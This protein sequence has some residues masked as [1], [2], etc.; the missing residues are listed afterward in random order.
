MKKNLGKL[1]AGL[2]V[3][4]VLAVIF[5]RGDQ[6]EHLVRTIEEGAP[7]FLILAVAFQMTKYLCQALSFSQCFRA[8]DARM[9][10]GECVRLVF[11]TYFLDTVIPSM[12]ISGTA[13]VVQQAT[14]RGI[15]PGRAVGAALLRQVT[16]SAAFIVIMVIGFAILA[17][18]GDLQPGWLIMGACAIVVV[19]ALVGAMV[20]AAL[21]PDWLLKVAAPFL[22]LADKVLARFKKKPVDD[23]VTQ[24]V[25]TYSTAAKLMVSNKADIAREFG[26]SVLANALEVT[27]FAFVGLAFGMHDFRVVICVYVV[28]TLSGMVSIVP[29]G[30]GVVEGA[31]LV[32]FTLFGV[33]QATGMAI[34]MVYRAIIFWLPFLIGAVL[35]QN[36][37]FKQQ[38]ANLADLMGKPAGGTGPD[39]DAAAPGRAAAKDPAGPKAQAGTAAAVPDGAR[40]S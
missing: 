17:I 3:I 12:N 36:T 33:E 10:Y 14:K 11:Q 29:Q 24:L 6:L 26:F 4:I 28:A 32:A 38:G 40:K 2:A 5:M 16:I 1:V 21:K 23:Q 27:C 8:V 35:M 37:G 31:S 19:G 9:P 13:I 20:L 25:D 39:A 34:I 7:L 15:Q 30:V 18:M 22:R